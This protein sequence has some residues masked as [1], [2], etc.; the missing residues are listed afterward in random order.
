MSTKA[1]TV[2]VPTNKELEQAVGFSDEERQ[3]IQG[4]IGEAAVHEFAAMKQLEQ[5][6]VNDRIKELEAAFETPQQ[7]PQQTEPEG[8]KPVTMAILGRDNDIDRAARAHA[9]ERLN[10][11]LNEGSGLRRLARRVWKGGI[12]NEYYRQLYIGQAKKEI[13]AEQDVLLYTDADDKARAAAS[14]SIL[15][16]FRRGDL[17]ID[18]EV[19]E[20]HKV[21]AGDSGLGNDI[22]NLV[23]AASKKNTAAQW[24]D[25]KIQEA[26]EK[27]LVRD[28]ARGESDVEGEREIQG[29]E[30]VTTTDLK[31]VIEAFRGRGMHD[32]ALEHA[33]RSMR[34][35]VGETRSGARTEANY[36]A[37]DRLIEALG[38]K[39]WVGKL[40][41]EATLSLL[42]AAG[43][44]A[45]NL[46]RGTAMRI[47][48]LGTPGVL[49]AAVGAAR[50][51]KRAK[52]DIAMHRSQRE[53]GK[54]FGENDKYRDKFD[55]MAY[56][57][58]LASEMTD[59]L[60]ASVDGE[61]LDAG[62]DDAL[63]FAL[64]KLAEATVR[65]DI[66]NEVDAAK[67]RPLIRYTNELS[68]DNEKIALRSA[69]A[70][71]Y[72]KLVARL[73][74]LDPAALERLKVNV[75]EHDV[76]ASDGSTVRVPQI[77]LKEYEEPLRE[78]YKAEIAK[79]DKAA[80]KFVLGQAAVGA[81]MGF[82]I[83]GASSFVL[84]EASH[85]VAEHLSSDAPS[86]NLN[87]NA[88]FVP[89]GNAANHLSVNGNN[90]IVE[91][92][93]SHTFTVKD[94]DGHDIISGLKQNP[95][96]T[97]DQ[98]SLDKLNAAAN[99][100]IHVET[101]HHD[102]VYETKTTSID[103][104]A[105]DH[106]N[107][108]Q[109]LQVSYMD[110][111]TANPDLNEEG[112]RLTYN[113]DGTVTIGQNMT[114]EG[115][116]GHG[117]MLD[118]TNSQG[119]V[120][121]M[122]FK[123]PDGSFLHKTFNY[124]Q[125]IPKPWAD[126]LYQKNDGTW[127]F[128][129]NGEVHWGKIQNGTFYSA[130]SL[131]GDGH[132]LDIP[133]QVVKTPEYFENKLT[134]PTVTGSGNH[135]IV[136]AVVL[137]AGRGGLAERTATPPVEQFLEKDLPLPGEGQPTP[138]PVAKKKAIEPA[139]G[140]LAIETRPDQIAIGSAERRAIE[141]APP[142]R[143]LEAAQLRRAIEQKKPEQP[144]DSKAYTRDRIA[145]L[146]QNPEARVGFS[147]ALGW[148]YSLIRTKDSEYMQRIEN[149]VETNPTM[150]KLAVDSD[151]ITPYAV[152]PLTDDA[153]AVYETLKNYGERSRQGRS[154]SRILLN[155][156]YSEADEAEHMDKIRGMFDAVA[157]V[158][159]DYPELQISQFETV[160][161]TAKQESGG[162]GNRTL[163]EVADEDMLEV[164]MEAAHRAVDSGARPADRDILVLKRPADAVLEST[165]ESNMIEAMHSHPEKD[166]F[167]G[168]VRWGMRDSY[169]KLPELGFLTNTIEVM[170]IMG[171]HT[172]R[173]SGLRPLFAMNMG[174]RLSSIAAIGGGGHYTDRRDETARPQTYDLILG[175]R[176]SAA[177]NPSNGA[178]VSQ[179]AT[180]GTGQ[181]S[182][183]LNMHVVRAQVDVNASALEKAYLSGQPIIDAILDLRGSGKETGAA[184]DGKAELDLSL[185]ATIERINDGMTDI[186]TKLNLT[187]AEY[188]PA[189]AFML[190]LQ[191]VKDKKGN[192]T[193]ALRYTV[194][195][196]NGKKIFRLTDGGGS[197]L[198]RQFRNNPIYGG[199][200]PRIG[201]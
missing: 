31:H 147:E 90:S 106:P 29:G 27:I 8:D 32:E 142:R 155:I 128:K 107:E 5:G 109:R 84:Q 130:A 189:L 94:A 112:G 154:M 196:E 150:E 191:Q 91:D 195:E 117:L 131:P 22:R 3:E 52:N 65:R 145:E 68:Q 9:D 2:A 11:E 12:A 74:N 194:E 159:T 100:G 92:P 116:R 77:D 85:A 136:P 76:E 49:G 78:V 170:K 200:K 47:A 169:N 88:N 62:G 135:E 174:Y 185:N 73:Q 41:P 137:T 113:H 69:E 126:M 148:H 48:G 110:N 179:Q 71:A 13:E 172:T 82:A 64:E 171:R 4:A 35:V 197:W 87:T 63:R 108:F 61:T 139:P 80:R 60:L 58:K 46:S 173:A 184:T 37:A 99:G 45:A 24:S 168:G 127:G 182:R 104:Y 30:R 122:S 164:I 50:A 36:S 57:D 134:V 193:H 81:A 120:L 152:N 14:E 132:S 83:S 188:G 33:V 38:K 89:Q 17:Y 1:D 66:T 138:P 153:D 44:T 199:E 162:Y 75:E 18:A 141:A 181:K 101:V 158:V 143:A 28:R 175:E 190:P 26:Y 79:A 192:V 42:V 6:Q 186:I 53:L 39:E 129:G 54:I 201:V 40:V 123:Q 55:D 115:S 187:E 19:G 140:R 93:D 177:R 105:K 72:T 86:L 149:I 25:D 16:R 133:S 156:R 183:D 160:L 51:R 166:T 198:L 161:E 165:Y 180:D 97:F 157:R 23:Y 56:P 121:D 70:Q 146:R 20:T 21:L 176:L 144:E 15:E 7:P 114:A 98:A 124:G 102:A 119:R 43:F 67:R 163:D 95:N 96:G 111:Y 59:E 34:I 118:M 178:Q 167:S 103:Q 151:G 10:Q 125:P